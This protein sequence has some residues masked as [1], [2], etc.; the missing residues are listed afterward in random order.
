MMIKCPNCN[1]E[2]EFVENESELCAECGGELKPPASAPVDISDLLR[3]LV[4]DVKCN[5]CGS[6]DTWDLSEKSREI[7]DNIENIDFDKSASAGCPYLKVEYNRNLF[8]LSNS[9]SIIKL[10]FTPLKDELLD[11]LVFM[12]AVRAE[13]VSRRQIPLREVLQRNRTFSLQIPFNPEGSCGRINFNFYIGCNVRGNF[14]YYHFS[15]NHKVYDSK[16]SGNAVCSQI[17]I[18]QEFNSNNAADINYRDSIG[19][20]LNRM[21]AKSLS[22]NEMI[23]RLN[24]L[25]PEYKVKELTETTWRPEDVLIKGNLYPATKLILE[26][27]GKQIFLFNQ[28]CVKFGRDPGQ[29]DLLVRCG[30]GNMGPREYPN[31]TVSKKHAEILYCEDAVKLFDHSSYGTYINGRK[32]DGAGIPLEQGATVEFGDIHWQM[33]IQKCYSKLP[34]NIC[35]TCAANKIKSVTF[36]RTD[37]EPEY[38]LL[39][40]QCCELGR[41]IDDLADWTVFSRNQSFFIRTPAQDFYHLRPGQ[42]VEYSNK[43]INVKYF[44]QF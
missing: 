25:P 40:W 22:V 15:I 33:N 9:E 43:K 26:Y 12:E 6:D 13:H 27:N 38:Y 7:A 4:T 41:V 19:E 32:P 29:V 24:D 20:A 23:D 31:S 10:K 34:H 39:V 3:K 28:P 11:L 5:D 42:P 17:T 36:K 35:Q 8:F 14:K 1:A 16:Q 30:Q 2:V 37:S 18:N 21:A 44:D